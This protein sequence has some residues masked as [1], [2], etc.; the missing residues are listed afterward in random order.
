MKCFECRG[1][2]QEVLGT[3][4]TDFQGRHIQ[5][6]N[7]PILEC[8]CCGEKYLAA[9]PSR[10]LDSILGYVKAANL[11]DLVVNYQDPIPQVVFR[12]M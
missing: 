5:I 11:K 8:T 2:L 12:E 7:M 6:T 1:L 4:E 3:Y 9:E 10:Y